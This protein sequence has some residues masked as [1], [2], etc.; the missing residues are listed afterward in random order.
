MNG[1]IRRILLLLAVLAVP[2][3]LAMASQLLATT[4]DPP[5]PRQ[6]PVVVE[7][8]AGDQGA[9]HGER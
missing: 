2:A 5:L 4:A 9:D 6:E 7:I 8:A 1:M 3:G